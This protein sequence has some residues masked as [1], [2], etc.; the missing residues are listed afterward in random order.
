MALGDKWSPTD[1]EWE[2]L[3]GDEEKNK[4]LFS[5]WP[6]ELAASLGPDCIV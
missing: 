6:P 4:K 2:V 5:D 3:I 1:R